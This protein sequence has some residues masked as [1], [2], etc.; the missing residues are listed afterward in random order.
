MR[1]VETAFRPPYFTPGDD[2]KTD[3]LGS[4]GWRELAFGLAEGQA[5]FWKTQDGE[6]LFAHRLGICRGLLECRCPVC[7]TPNDQ[8]PV[9]PVEGGVTATK[10]WVFS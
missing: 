5:V 3:G 9:L 6:D 1:S 4:H 7:A 8:E 2:C 10:D